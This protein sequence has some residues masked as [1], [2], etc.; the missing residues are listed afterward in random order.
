MSYRHL[1]PR[2]SPQWVPRLSALSLQALRQ[3]RA[4]WTRDREKAA[5]AAHEAC[6]SEGA[7]VDLRTVELDGQRFRA[8]Y[9]NGELVCLLPPPQEAVPLGAVQCAPRST[10]NP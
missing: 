4:E 8:L 3:R 1:L 10:D 5:E 7:E 9:R 6:A 2:L